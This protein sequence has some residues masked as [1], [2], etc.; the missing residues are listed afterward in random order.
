MNTFKSTYRNMKLKII[1][2]HIYPKKPL[3]KTLKY[4]SMKFHNALAF[5][6]FITVLKVPK[7]NTVFRL[8]T[9]L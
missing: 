4:I 6:R 2:I 8:K 3:V 9:Y 7:T 1:S 5:F